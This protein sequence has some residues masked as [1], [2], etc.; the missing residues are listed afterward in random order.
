VNFRT[1]PR[2]TMAVVAGAFIGV[3]GAVASVAPAGAHAAALVPHTGHDAA[4]TGVASCTPDRWMVRWKLTTSDTHG[5]VGVVSNIKFTA[6]PMKSVPGGPTTPPT[7]TK[8]V[9]GAQFT[10][11]GV[12]AEDQTFDHHTSTAVLSFTLTWHDGAT[13]HDAVVRS[14]A[15][16]PAGCLAGAPVGA[17]AGAPTATPTVRPPGS[18]EDPTGATPTTAAPENPVL[19]SSTVAAPAAAGGDVTGG[20]GGGLAVT[21]AA[22]GTIAGGAVLLVGAGGLLF[23]ASRRRRVRFTA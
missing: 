2:R 14:T 18:V 6:P 10:G 4:L 20:G 16:V 9:E 7:L 21:G 11:D 23:V 19:P 12:F 5:A 13:V 8:F 1:P 15:N 3:V 22:A 17:P